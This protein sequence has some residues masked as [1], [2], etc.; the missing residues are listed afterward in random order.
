MKTGLFLISIAVLCFTFI[1][2]WIMLIG[3]VN[4]H[5]KTYFKDSTTFAVIVMAVLLI[6]FVVVTV[7]VLL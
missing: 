6:A 1:F 5:E 2:I 7:M 4:G 3:P